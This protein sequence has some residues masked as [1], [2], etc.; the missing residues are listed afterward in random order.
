MPAVSCAVCRTGRIPCVSDFP[1]V[2]GICTRLARSTLLILLAIRSSRPDEAESVV[3]I[4]YLILRR[5]ILMSSRFTAA[6]RPVHGILDG[7]MGR[8]PSERGDRASAQNSGL[9]SQGAESCAQMLERS[10]FCCLS[11]HH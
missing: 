8:L 10:N 1:L 2:A 3:H 7:A 11:L 6:R 5:A 9:I 4:H